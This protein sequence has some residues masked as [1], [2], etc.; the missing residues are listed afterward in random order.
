[1]HLKAKQYDTIRYGPFRLDCNSALVVL[2][3][4][5]EL[6]HCIYIWKSTSPRLNPATRRVRAWRPPLPCESDAAQSEPVEPK[7]SIII[8]DEDDP[9]PWFVYITL[10]APALQALSAAQKD[11]QL[12][13]QPPS[14]DNPPEQVRCHFNP[15]LLPA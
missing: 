9:M 7:A 5:G 13:I 2:S 8:K 1:M 11:M 15:A 3:I 4:R 10:N 12:C 14:N 6:H